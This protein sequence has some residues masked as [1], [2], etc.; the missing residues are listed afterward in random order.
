MTFNA[1]VMKPFPERLK[2]PN[3]AAQTNA[4]NYQAVQ[5]QDNFTTPIFWVPADKRTINPYWNN[6]S[7]E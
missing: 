6:Y 2:Y 4:D 7:Y 5:A 1:V 3:S